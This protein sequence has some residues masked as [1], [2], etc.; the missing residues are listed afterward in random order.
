MQEYVVGS[1][2]AG[3]LEHA[4]TSGKAAYWVSQGAGEHRQQAR[5][6]RAECVRRV[7]RQ[8]SK[9]RHSHVPLRPTL[10]LHAGS[11]QFIRNCTV[12]ADSR[13]A[14]SAGA[15]SPIL[16]TSKVPCRHR[17]RLRYECAILARTALRTRDTARTHTRRTITI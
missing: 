16:T 4:K 3:G 2:Q 8:S 13:V 10:G 9:R 7:S 15:H 17:L 14:H 6:V 12:V 5:K 1:I 11:I